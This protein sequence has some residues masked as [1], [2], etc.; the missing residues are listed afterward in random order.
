MRVPTADLPRRS[1][2]LRGWLIAAA[3][4]VVV[5][6][7]SVR[8]LA[9]F[10]TDF[11]WFEEVGFDGTWRRLLSAK[12]VPALIFSALFFVF[13]LVNLIVADRIAPRYRAAGPEDEIIERYRTYVAPYAG[14]L[15]V[16]VAAFF[17]LIMG[18][19]VSAEWRNWILFSNSVD[20]GVEEPQ[21]NRDI[22]FYVFRLPFLQFAVGWTFAALL[23]VLIVTAVFHYLNGGIRLQSPWQRVTPQV[24]VHLSVILALMALTKTA[25]YYLARFDLVFSRRG[26]VDG[27]SYTDVK[28]QLPALNLLMIISVA[29]AVLFIANIWRRGWVFPIIAVG[30]WAFISLVVGTI[31]P[32]VIQ[33]VVVRPNEPS[34]ERPYIERN[35]EATRA[36]FGLDEVE[37]RRFEYSTDLE[38]A[39][40]AANNETLSNLRLWDPP[41]LQPALTPQEIQT[42]YT[43]N[44]VDVDR[45]EVGSERLLTFVAPRELDPERI[46]DRTW[47]NRHLVYTHGYGSVAVDGT[48]VED[49]EPSYLLQGIDPPENELGTDVDFR[50]VYFGED[51]GGYAIVDTEVPEQQAASDVETEE[52]RYTGAA[53]VKVSNIVKRLAFAARFGDWNIVVSGQ[54]NGDSRVLYKRDVRDRVET[55]APFLRF[56]S[57]PY[58]V[59]IDGRM[60]WLIDAYT[61][62]DR[63]PYSQSL[64]PRNLPDGSGLDTSF[65]YVRNSV[66]ATVDAYDGTITFYVVDEEDPI[67]KA[68]R[69]AFPELFTDEDE[70]P[71]GLRDHWRY[72]EDLFRA[73][74]EHYTQYH[75][76]DPDEF[77]RKQALWDIAPTPESQVAETTATTRAGNDGGRN[78]ALPPS[79]SPS[80]PLYLTLQLPGNEGQEFVLTRSFVP[81]AK[82][83][84]LSAFIAARSDGANYGNL[85]VYELPANLVAPSP[86][87]AGSVIQSERAISEQI[88]LLTRAQSQ[89]VAGEVQLIPIGNSVV[90]V[91][92]IYVDPRGEGAYAR[93]RFL[94]IAY[95]ERAVLA[96]LDPA[97]GSSAYPSVEEALT[98]LINNE[99]PPLPEDDDGDDGETPGTTPE[100]PESSTT[101][102]TPDTTPEP[103]TAAELIARAI[104]EFAAADRALAQGGPN[105]LAEY[106]EHVEEARRLIAEA[107]E[108]VAGAAT[109]TTSTPVSNAR[110]RR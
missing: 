20:F 28:A 66:K 77:Y 23:V 67:I 7:L 70:M 105:A 96:D 78:T 38:E 74:T 9:R 62:T 108:L 18:G 1:L 76:T 71:A 65:N 98:A 45:Y 55:A 50:G 27:A 90:Y 49:G 25:Q 61:T 37:V 92:P 47:T 17:A 101:T 84:Q 59:F 36:A 104:E 68:Y 51:F 100:T 80:P 91:R 57:D 31:Y 86:A 10:Y 35:I 106:Q 26:V 72:P 79:G 103:G 44:D 34:R 3:I 42:F 109:T 15:R 107:N 33:Q 85:I 56:D 12:A 95:D 41:M 94:A 43:F 22:G 14:R 40:V 89:V 102:T 63:Y 24:K 30:L 32:A 81:R 21:F 48:T 16:L 99:E 75:M 11:L 13:L 82:P 83:N 5:L 8:G 88:T 110:L 97:P 73:Q 69:R 2:G 54:I 52:V 29:A 53:G 39:D 93:V 87:R 46:P 58:P 4:L 19:G 64:N 6:L 60:L